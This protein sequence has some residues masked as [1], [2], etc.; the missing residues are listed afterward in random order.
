MIIER[1]QLVA[2][3]LDAGAKVVTPVGTPITVEYVIGD[4]PHYCIIVGHT[5]GGLTY[6]ARVE[7]HVTL[8]TWK[9]L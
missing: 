6:R 7:R 9:G 8:D 1:Q 3:A 4:G 5:V 2:A